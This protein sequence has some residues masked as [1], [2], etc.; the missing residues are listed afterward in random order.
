MTAYVI[1][2]LLQGILVI[3]LVSIGTFGI[4]QMAPGDPV[5]VLVGQAQVTP[6]QIA[7]IKHKWGLDRPWYVQYLVWAKNM[8]RGDFGTSIVRTG[9]PV[10]HML[11]EAVPVTLKLNV[12]AI[13]FSILISVPVGMLAAIKRNSFIDYVSMVG[14]TL[15]VALPSFWLALVGI[16]IFALKL[17]W[18]PSTGLGTWKHWVLP[19]AVLSIEQTALI[20]RLTRSSTLEVLRQ[21]F[22]TTAY[23]K[24]LSR[25][26]VV[27]RHVA[28]N[29]MLPVITVLGIRV[30]WLLSGTVIVET[31]FGWPGVGRLFLDSVLR[32]DYQ[33]VQAIVLL[34]SVLVVMTNLLTD[35]VYAFIDPRIRLR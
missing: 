26:I 9:V 27:L 19:V 15:G 24:G 13:L 34:A 23:A 31:I 29:A 8:L 10:Q 16:M 5:D 17:G 3:F 32:L 6:A 4:L 14:A 7:A 2:R 25:K 33:V 1:Q 20:A 28:R 12:L 21:D 30:A 11:A 35:I 18:L 22:V